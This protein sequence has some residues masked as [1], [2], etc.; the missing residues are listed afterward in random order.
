MKHE[1]LKEAAKN[2]VKS[3]W[4]SVSYP[5]IEQSFS[6]GAKFQA[7]RMYS[8]E[9]VLKIITMSRKICSIDGNIDLD[10]DSL[11]GNLEGFS[12]KY[13]VTE[14]FEQFKNK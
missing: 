3:R 9:E 13:T 6:E 11:Q 2:Y 10:N 7:E 12:M 5:D 8:E 1:T 4:G 14:M